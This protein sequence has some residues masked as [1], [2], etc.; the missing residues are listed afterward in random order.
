MKK[1]VTLFVAGLM[2][3][4]I[5]AQTVKKVILEDFTGTWCGWCP[6]GTGVIETI[7]AA[8]PTRF[9]PV[10]TH[11]GDPLS[12]PDGDAVEAALAVSSWPAG[13]IDR[14]KFSGEA[15]I[16]TGRGKW[17]S[18][19]SQRLAGGAIASISFDNVQKS[20]NNYSGNVKIKFTSQ[21]T[22]GVPIKIN[23]LVLEDSIP[24]VGQYEQNNESASTYQPGNNPLVNFYHMDVL[25]DAVMTT[26]GTNANI[27]AT[28]V[29][30]VEYSEPFVYIKPTSLGQKNLR[31]VA[32]VAYDGTVAN[33][34]KEILNAE[35]FSLRWLEPVG[36]NDVQKN[37]LQVNVYPNPATKNSFVHTS[38][39][40]KQ[41]ATVTMEVLNSMGQVIS[42][43]Y[44]SYEI[45]G[46]H[47]IQWNPQEYSNNILPGVYFIS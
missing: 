35:T 5:Q 10:A 22:A 24:A 18:F 3:N 6:E 20:A 15:K 45:A 37:A 1:I 47:S 12:V 44:T 8:N 39:T 11:S 33:N 32:Y 40:L 14:Y 26:W 9:I 17:S 34:Q 13:A 29:V 2:V 43:P 42:K 30:G 16:P 38:F 7:T 25:R 19:V 41:D 27:P 23:V 46:S 31:L 28:P 4:T 36:V 21:P